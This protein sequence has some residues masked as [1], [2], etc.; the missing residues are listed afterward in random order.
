MVTEDTGSITTTCLLNAINEA[1]DA[2]RGYDTK[3][4]ILGILMTLVVGFLNYNLL[5]DYSSDLLIKL[6]IAAGTLL[7]ITAVGLMLIVL[8]PSNNPANEVYLGSYTPKN[9]YFFYKKNGE[10]FDF[11]KIHADLTTTDWRKELLFELLKLSHIRD[12]KHAWFIRAVKASSVTF[13]IVV[14]MAAR[15][16]YLCM[17]T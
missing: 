2:I 5:S 6:G 14:C 10:R 4:E 15:I 3:A 13:F 9:T 17:A 1:Q 7:A 8:F 16:G 11:E 12:R